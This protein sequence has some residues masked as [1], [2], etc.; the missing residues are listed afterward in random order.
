MTYAF[1]NKRPPLELMMLHEDGNSPKLEQ[2]T[3]AK[4]YLLQNSTQVG[5]ST[6][7]TYPYILLKNIEEYM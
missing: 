5:N 7:K 6:Y 4:K 2:F 1:S 3:L